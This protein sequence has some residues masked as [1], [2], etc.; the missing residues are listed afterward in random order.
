MV[1]FVSEDPTQ[2]YLI[3]DPERSFADRLLTWFGFGVAFLLV[4]I[5]AA[6]A[7]ALVLTV[8]RFILWAYGA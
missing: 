3:Q 1:G 6:F 4:V 5:I 7:G 2:E 8:V